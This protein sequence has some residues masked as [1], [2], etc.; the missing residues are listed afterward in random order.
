[1]R[2]RQFI[3]GLAGA[4]AWTA[5]RGVDRDRT[6]AVDDIVPNPPI[7]TRGPYGLGSLAS[8]CGQRLLRS[9]EATAGVGYRPGFLAN[10][11]IAGLPV[12]CAAL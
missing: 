11:L 10:G 1:M 7:S 12:P 4:T 6:A 9:A 8:N 3:A 2:W 5:N